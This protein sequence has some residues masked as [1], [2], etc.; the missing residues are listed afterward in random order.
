MKK[1]MSDS[2]ARGLVGFW[3][4]SRGRFVVSL[5]ACIAALIVVLVGCAGPSST[6]SATTTTPA[7]ETRGELSLVDTI[8]VNGQGTVQVAPDRATVNIGVQTQA[9]TAAQALDANSREVERVVARL[10]NEGI[11]ADA[12]RTSNV[13]VFPITTYDPDTGKQTTQGYQAENTVTVTVDD[14]ELL[15]KVLAGAAEAGSNYIYGLGFTLRDPTE[16]SAQA[17][18]KAM[19]QARTKAEGLA[20]AAGVKLGDV[21]ALREAS[22]QAIPLVYETRTTAT[23]G[24]GEVTPVPVSGGLLEVSASVDVTFRIVR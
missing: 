23:A 19:A 8:T 14:T 7:S 9:P 1:H 18:A 6:S 10:K 20:Q 21:V 17:L 15:G 11:P 3:E 2:K 5:V 4:S 24:A 22:A 12:I 16:A 13:N